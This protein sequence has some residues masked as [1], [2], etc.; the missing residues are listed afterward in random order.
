MARVSPTRGSYAVAF[1]LRGFVSNIL[2]MS[3]ALLLWAV[4]LYCKAER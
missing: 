2:L 3:V 4:V 1:D